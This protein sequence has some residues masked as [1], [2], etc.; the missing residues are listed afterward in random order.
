MSNR[1]LSRTSALAVA[2]SL[3]AITLA[4]GIARAE[5]QKT[6]PAAFARGAKAWAD[7]CARCHNLRDP[8]E[9]RDDQWKPVVTHMRIRAGLTGQE[10][11][12]ILLFLQGSN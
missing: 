11:R 10:A 4:T 6:D 1:N 3:L 9:L 8:K 12:D 5:E 7:N 2:A